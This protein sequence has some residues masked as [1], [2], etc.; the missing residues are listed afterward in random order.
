MTLMGVGIIGMIMLM[1]SYH[2]SVKVME[3]REFQ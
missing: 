3:K 1:I 2:V